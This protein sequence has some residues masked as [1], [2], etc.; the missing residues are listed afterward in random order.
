M[1]EWARPQPAPE[2]GKY[3]VDFPGYSRTGITYAAPASLYTKSA[4]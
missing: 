1:S 3:I 2:K 4:L